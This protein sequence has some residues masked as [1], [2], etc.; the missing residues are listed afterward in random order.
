MWVSDK[1]I[2]KAIQAG[3]TRLSAD[4]AN[5]SSAHLLSGI[6]IAVSE[7]AARA[8]NRLDSLRNSCSDAKRIALRGVT[9]AA[10][11][12][13]DEFS[14]RALALPEAP[15]SD[16]ATI[17]TTYGIAKQLLVD[18]AL[19][20]NAALNA[21]KG[22]EA[23][24]KDVSA[25]FLEVARHD[26][27]R[28]VQNA[29]APTAQENAQGTALDVESLKHYFA[30]WQGVVKLPGPLELIEA[31]QLSGGFSRQTILI[32]V[33]D[34]N[35]RELPLVIRKEV[36]GGF[37]DGACNTLIEEKPFFELCHQHSLPVPELFW[38]ETDRTI[39]N[40]EFFVTECM[41]GEIVGSSY[42]MAEG[43]DDG[44]FQQL[45]QLMASLH[46]I[47]WSPFANELRASSRI[48]ASA[49]I[50]AEQAALA[51]VGQFESY[52]RNANL[53]ALPTIELMVDWLKRNIPQTNR[54]VVLCHGDIGFHNLL[55]KDGRVSAVLD[56]ETSRLSDPARD[57]SYIYPM[58][59]HYVDW[60]QFMS[61]YREAGGPE[62]DQTSLD[63]YNVFCAF[64]H[65]IV[66]E[67]AM[68]DTFPRSANPDLGY[69]H[70]GLPIKAYFF[71]EILRDGAPIWG[72]E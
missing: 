14:A 7:L 32:K 27:Q 50:N 69:L 44:F 12:G 52:W 45:A 36:P 51:M 17:D 25:F 70:L 18:C 29:T 66:C 30:A 1:Q 40:G 64:A 22:D 39:L 53:D 3:L 67:V 33:R 10:R 6:S 8:D 54:Q 20:L 49:P 56:W 48:P 31:R 28:A 58:V 72:S 26:T 46:L 9:L 41:P 35:G 21:G 5:T 61:W 57:L 24:R 2:L 59:T 65:V 11:I 34:A 15:L 71:N 68:G 62:V 19:S 63:Y 38:H 13:A 42:Q 47:D 16:L 23:W 43:L 37:L 4:L 55:V 60:D